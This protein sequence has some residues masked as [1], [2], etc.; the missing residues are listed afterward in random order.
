MH[1]NLY[2]ISLCFSVE[3]SKGVLREEE[4]MQLTA[5]F[6]S[7]KSGDFEARL[8]LNYESGNNT[9]HSVILRSRIEYETLQTLI[10]KFSTTTELPRSL[11]IITLQYATLCSR[12]DRG[13]ALLIIAWLVDRLRVNSN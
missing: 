8:H 2:N 9:I 12:F 13:G 1:N 5:T 6:L 11:T 3:P 4:T 10:L 7:E